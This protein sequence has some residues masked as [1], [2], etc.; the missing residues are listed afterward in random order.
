[1]VDEG[2]RQLIQSLTRR[3]GALNML[4]APLPPLWGKVGMGGA[5]ARLSKRMLGNFLC[6]SQRCLVRSDRRLC[7]GTPH[8][9]SPRFAALTKASH[10]SPTRGEEERHRAFCLPLV[11]LFLDLQE[12]QLR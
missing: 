10:P 9:A 3:G 11:R 5:A 4:D 7:G 2:L 6:G 8:S 1:M 12:L